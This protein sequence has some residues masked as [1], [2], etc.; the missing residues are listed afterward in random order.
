MAG[1]GEHDER[2][3]TWGQWRRDAIR[4]AAQA[5]G[6]YYPAGGTWNHFKSFLADMHA[7]TAELAPPSW[8]GVAFDLATMVGPGALAKLVK[9]TGMTNLAGPLA[10]SRPWQVLRNAPTARQF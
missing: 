8:K 3:D 9:V 7:S 10:T 1:E 6:E 4:D 2:L 5:A